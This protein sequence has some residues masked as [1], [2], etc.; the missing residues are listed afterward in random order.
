MVPSMEWAAQATPVPEHLAHCECI[1]GPQ[2]NAD[3]EGEYISP[4]EIP[5]GKQYVSH[6]ER[7]GTI[8][9]RAAYHVYFKRAGSEVSH[10]QQR[11]V[12]ID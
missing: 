4:V 10:Y 11:G 6:I 5:S 2:I 1:P 9:K 12:R 8:C 7:E 3:Q